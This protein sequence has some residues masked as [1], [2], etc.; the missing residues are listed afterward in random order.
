MEDNKTIELKP[1]KSRILVQILFFN[2]LYI[3]DTSTNIIF[4][5][6]SYI[7]FFVG[8]EYLIEAELKHGEIDLFLF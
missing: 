8:V 4:H 3:Q 1:L 7:I 5:Y 2:L 6:L